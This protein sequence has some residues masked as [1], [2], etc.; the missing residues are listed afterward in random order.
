M[1]QTS[2]DRPVPPVANRV[3]TTRSFHGDTFVD[4]YEWLRD[5]ESPET[6]GYLEAE[7]AYTKAMTAH[8]GHLREAI[9]GEIKGRTLET[10]LSVPSRS[11]EHWYYSRTIEGKQYPVMCRVAVTDPDDWTPPDLPPGGA[12]DGE[13]VLLDCNDLADGYDFFSLGAFSVSLDESTL[14]YAIDVVG[15]ERYTI[16]L[17]PLGSGEQLPDEIPNTLHGATWS[18]DGSHLFYCTVDDAWRPEKVWRH[19]VG[20]PGTDLDVCVFHESDEKFWVTVDRTTSDRFIVIQSGSRVTSEVR[21]LDA[22]SPTDQPSE[23]F[24]RRE[25]VEYSVDHAVIAGEDRWLVLHN[26]GAPN[27]TLA[28]G[29]L[30]V[31]SFDDL[32]TLVPHDRSVR[33]GDVQASRDTIAVTLRE[34]GLAQVRVFVLDEHGI[35]QGA[36]IA[37]DE[38]MFTASSAGFSDWRQ[39][40]V[41][42]SYESWLTPSTVHDYDPVARTSTVRKNQPVIGNDA[43]RF[44]Q[45]REWVRSRDGVDIPLSLVR[46]RDVTPGAGTPLLLYGYGSYEISAD[47]R[48]RIPILSLLERGMVFAVAHVRGGGEMGRSWYDDGKLLAKKNTFNDFVDCA[49]HLVESGWT[50]AERLVAH[51]GGAGGLLMGAVANQAP[52]LFAGIVAHVP[53]V[54]AL[55]TILDP[56]LPLTVIEWD[57]WGDP[58]H[59]PEV[60]AYMKSYTPYENVTAT[61]YPAIYALTSINDTRVPQRPEPAK[62]I[63]QLRATVTPGHPILFKCEMSAGHGGASGRYD[64][65]REIADYSAW[66]VDVAGAPT[67]RCTTSAPVVTPGAAT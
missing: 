19:R 50:S 12:P 43:D 15:D 34:G 57:E 66:V 29:G 47:P 53:F 8:L 61:H 55:T 44:V 21:V 2:T 65:W 24:P 40:Y 27:F 52:D 39:P 54:D 48:M 49:R 26:D 1:T 3:P 64:F 45:T 32:E 36:N 46:H 14:A 67:T 38:S 56:E 58:L 22:D 60:Y 13:Q 20:T 37:F 63:A 9:F 11:G 25:G 18:S 30:D 35:G 23:L 7:N 51:G 6:L 4:S 16:R 10:D 31:H 17:R 42:L 5:K 59:D 33:L 62:W 28:V 41:R